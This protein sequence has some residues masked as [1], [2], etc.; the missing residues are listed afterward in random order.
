MNICA[1]LKIKIPRRIT[2][3]ALDNSDEK[4]YNLIGRC[5]TQTMPQKEK[6]T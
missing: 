4:L 2:L 5:R 3:N 6:A 1:G